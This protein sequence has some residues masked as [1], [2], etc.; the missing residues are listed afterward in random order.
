MKWND[1]KN[2]TTHN[3]SCRVQ[4]S[5]QIKTPGKVGQEQ[6]LQQTNHSH[7]ATRALCT[8]A[9]NLPRFF[10]NHTFPEPKSSWHEGFDAKYRCF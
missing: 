7:T 1:E 8:V 6:E 2:Y 4:A 10:F 5:G 9:L 3:S